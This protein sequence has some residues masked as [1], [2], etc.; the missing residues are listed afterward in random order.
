MMAYQQSLAATAP[1]APTR[2]KKKRSGGLGSGFLKL[3]LVAALCVGGYFALDWAMRPPIPDYPERQFG[4]ATLRVTARSGLE[5]AV[6][7]GEIDASGLVSR[8][9]WTLSDGRSTTVL[10]DPTYAYLSADGTAWKRISW[11]DAA[12]NMQLVAGLLSMVHFS[13]WVPAA[14]EDFVTI[15]TRDPAVLGGVE[16]TR[17]DIVI[18]LPEFADEEP[19]AFRAYSQR[20]GLT[21]EVAVSMTVYVDDNGFVWRLESVDGSD[22]GADTLVIELISVSDGLLLVEYPTQFEETDGRVVSLA[23]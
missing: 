13:D 8:S 7:Q 4:T 18:D 6:V 23:G 19:D 9:T 21:S 16:L 10:S 15:N 11:D 5:T 1:S 17:Y 12:A 20:T 22:G 2:R 3:A 14:A